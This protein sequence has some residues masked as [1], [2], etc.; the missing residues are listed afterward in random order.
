MKRTT[1][2]FFLLALISKYG[3]V[4]AQLVVENNLTV[5]DLVE[6]IFVGQGVTV[7]NVTFNGVPGNQV[8]AQAGYFNSS[9][10]NIPITTGIILAS[11]D[12]DVAVGPNNSGGAGSNVGGTYQ[13]DD[14]NAIATASTN[15]AAV[16]EFDFIPAGDTL[17]FNYVFASEE[18]NEYVCSAF[19]DVF[20][21]FLSGP[22]LSGPY[23]N[24]G[25]N[26]AIIPETTLPVAI[27]NVNNGSIGSA[28]SGANCSV[29][30]LNNT[31]YYIDNESNG[32]FSSTQYDGFTVTLQAGAKVECGQQ[33]HIKLAIADAADAI[34][35]SGVFLEESC[36]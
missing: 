7:S 27:N 8:K 14:L 2:L 33:Y 25:I 18:Y 31:E 1:L 35:D 4:S 9:N 24:G 32:A 11:G 21:F 12:V 30:Q 26:I 34:L 16:L 13:D 29:I 20:G 5:V 19:N 23:D 22:G 3:S 17:T 36:C 15:N 10:S 6:S 28:G